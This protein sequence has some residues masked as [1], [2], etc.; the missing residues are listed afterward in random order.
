MLNDHSNPYRKYLN[1]LKVT[2]RFEDDSEY[3]ENFHRNQE[4]IEPDIVSGPDTIGHPRTVMIVYTHTS[5]ANFTM[6]RSFRFEQ[7]AIKA[8][9][10][11]MIAPKHLEIILVL[12]DINI[13]WFLLGYNHK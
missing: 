1:D 10:R 3:H 9:L 6:S 7:H 5:F 13:S 12:F 8:H 2:Y 4:G 11:R